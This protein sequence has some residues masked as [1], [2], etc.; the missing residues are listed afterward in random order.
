[1]GKIAGMKYLVV[2]Q[3]LSREG[4]PFVDI[5]TSLTNLNTKILI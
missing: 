3:D 2:E 5:Q 1:V 4:T